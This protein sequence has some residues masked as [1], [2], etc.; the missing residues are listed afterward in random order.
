MKDIIH[1]TE[2]KLIERNTAEAF[3]KL[4]NAEMGSSYEI[5]EH[6]DA[7]DFLCCDKDGREL[8]LEITLTEDRSGDIQ[9]LLGRSDARSLEHLERHL[10]AV[11]RGEERIFDSVSC[12][13]GNVYQMAR[14]RIQPKL[15]KDYGRNAALVVRDTSGV[16]WS[17]ETVIADIASSLDLTTNPFDKGIWLMSLA[18]NKISRVV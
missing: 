1:S 7:P 12:L 17:W 2:K 13:K 11:K 8:R 10:T 16:T 15:T 14:D 18:S 5:V 4:Y 9:A 3:L 6:S